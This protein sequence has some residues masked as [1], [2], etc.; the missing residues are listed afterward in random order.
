M[1]EDVTVLA[2]NTALLSSKDQAVGLVSGISF[3]NVQYTIGKF[4]NESRPIHDYRPLDYPYE[5]IEPTIPYNVE[6][7]YV[8]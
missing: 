2:E 7:F 8:E 6:G 3:K 1:F 5:S 4:G